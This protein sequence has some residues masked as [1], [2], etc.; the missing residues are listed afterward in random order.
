MSSGSSIVQDLTVVHGELTSDDTAARWSDE[1]TLPINGV[2]EGKEMGP[3]CER[4]V[5]TQGDPPLNIAVALHGNNGINP[6]PEKSKVPRPYG[7]FSMSPRFPHW[8]PLS[9][10]RP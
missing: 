10:S 1:R 5:Q 3:R 6:R 8:S 2:L 4:P 9:A 7:H